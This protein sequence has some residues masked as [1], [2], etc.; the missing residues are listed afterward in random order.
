[1]NSIDDRILVVH[2]PETT[3]LI[4]R[5]G[6]GTAEEFR[7]I[8][9]PWSLKDGFHE[10]NFGLG[11]DPQKRMFSAL[12]NGYFWS[13]GGPTHRGRFRSSVMRYDLEGHV[14]EWGRGF[15]TP[16]GVACGPDGQ[17]FFVDN[18][19]DWVQVCKLVHCRKGLF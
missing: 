1:M 9:G 5:D 16:D 15:R 4:D 6:D 11:V 12:N 8:T 2:R 17:A 7:C 18:Q 10:Y 3:E 19:G 14:E 13:Y